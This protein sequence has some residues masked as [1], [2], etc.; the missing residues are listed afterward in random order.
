MKL[1]FSPTPQQWQNGMA[2]E[3]DSTVTEFLNLC[4]NRT[5]ASVY[6]EIKVKN[7]DTSVE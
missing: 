1:E 2:K 3:P 5:N 7:T 4:Q 6:S